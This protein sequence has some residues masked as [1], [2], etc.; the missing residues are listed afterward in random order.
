MKIYAPI[1]VGELLDKLTIL[2]IKLQYIK[3]DSKLVNIQKE[4]KILK[5]IADSL[6]IK[7][8]LDSLYKELLFVNQQLWDIEDQKRLHEKQK[9]F[10]DQFIQLAR[11]VYV[12]NDYRAKIKKD[13]NILMDSDI[14]EE[15]SY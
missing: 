13:I 8:G 5:E 7:P 4:H 3:D 6:K 15:K 14:I 2:T 1:S 9:K 11:Q 12:Q 10:N